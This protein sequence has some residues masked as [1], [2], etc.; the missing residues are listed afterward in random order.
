MREGVLGKNYTVYIIKGFDNNGEFEV[1]RR[2]KEFLS[3]R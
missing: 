1:S 3:L 2:F